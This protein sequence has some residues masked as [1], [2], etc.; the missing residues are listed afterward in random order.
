MAVI[1]VV[2]ARHR[3][4]RRRRP[5]GRGEGRQI[6]SFCLIEP[7]NIVFRFAQQF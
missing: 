4:V 6:V 7:T 2:G 5:G 1:T 3:R